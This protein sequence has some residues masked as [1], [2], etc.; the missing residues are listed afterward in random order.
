M[1]P[2]SWVL[3]DKWEQR[4]N[5][6][7]WQ[8]SPLFCQFPKITTLPMSF[9]Y[10]LYRTNL[11]IL[12]LQPSN[13]CSE[14]FHTEFPEHTQILD[15]FHYLSQPSLLQSSF[16]PLRG[17]LFHLVNLKALRFFRNLCL[18]LWLSLSLTSWAAS[19]NNLTSNK[20]P[21]ADL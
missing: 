8:P 20:Q 14:K 13:N 21:H 5:Q 2:K 12:E 11:V 7:K 15:I 1:L 4:E 19:C 3:C 6:S 18:I 9:P 10:M 16:I 17:F